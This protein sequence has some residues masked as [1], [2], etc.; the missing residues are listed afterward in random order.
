MSMSVST[1][2]PTEAVAGEPEESYEV[3]MEEAIMYAADVVGHLE[4]ILT[5][6]PVIGIA[7]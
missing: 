2:V 6:H 7:A 5:Y 4:Y 1:A 3:S